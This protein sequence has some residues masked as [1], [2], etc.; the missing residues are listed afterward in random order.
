MKFEKPSASLRK[1]IKK[2]MITKEI[3]QDLRAFSC[4]PPCQ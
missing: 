2:I 1:G 4:D 3:V